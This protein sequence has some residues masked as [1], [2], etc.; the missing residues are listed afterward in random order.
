MGIYRIAD[1]IVS[2]EP[3]YDRIR[4][5]SKPYQVSTSGENVQISIEISTERR[6]L[7]KEKHPK[8]SESGC[9][10]ILTGVAFNRQLLD[11]G[12]FMIHASAVVVDG[13]AYLFTADPGTGKSTHTALWL[14][15]FGSRAFIINDDK[16]VLRKE[17]DGYR[18]YGTPW[19]GKT[20]QNRN[21]SAKLGGII[22]LE[23][24]Q[25]NW[26]RP[27]DPKCACG[28]LLRQTIHHGSRQQMLQ[29]LTFADE[30]LRTVK[31]CDMGCNISKEAVKMAY[32]E[33][34]GK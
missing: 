29:M 21:T 7:F 22:F 31:V 24:S 1:L 6:E 8:V 20:D 28:K 4:R 25:E 16:P 33:M 5:Q 30:L 3:M 18:V 26:I 32:K 17:T 34:G 9:E 11:F 15:Y 23:R 27:A 2:M 14:Q 10:Y 12:G 19:S 13:R